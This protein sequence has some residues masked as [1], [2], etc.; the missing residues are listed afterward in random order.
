MSDREEQ[1]GLDDGSRPATGSV[2]NPFAKPTDE[3]I[4]EE[5]RGVAISRRRAATLGLISG[6]V[7]VGLLLICF[8]IVV[9]LER[10][11]T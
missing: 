9:L 10:L 6:L 4:A 11:T 1:P 3:E 8:V 2:A 5:M 7:M